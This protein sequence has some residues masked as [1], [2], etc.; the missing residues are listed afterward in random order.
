MLVVLE[1]RF[2][3]ENI[4]AIRETLPE[5]V[6]Y[7]TTLKGL[8]AGY[9][10]DF[11]DFAAY[12]FPNM[13]IEVLKVDF[14]TYDAMKD[15]F[16]TFKEPVQVHLHSSNAL[17]S[18][19][20]KGLCDAYNYEGL[21]VDIMQNALFTIQ[22]DGSKRLKESLKSLNVENYIDL[23]GGVIIKTTSDKHL[24]DPYTSIVDYISQHFFEWRR[25]K[26]VLTN[27]QLMLHPGDGPEKVIIEE[28]RMSKAEYR[29]YQKFREFLI[30]KHIAQFKRFKN[31][32]IELSFA[33]PE[34]KNFIFITGSW[35]ESL[36]YR[37]IREINGVEDVK[38]GV[39][40]SWEGDNTVLRNELDVLATYQ[41]RL[42]VFSCKDTAKYH[43]GTL[44]ELMVYAQ[45]I[46][47]THVRKILVVTEMPLK[48]TVVERAQEMGIS[49]I[50]F[51]GSLTGF[52][53]QIER[54]FMNAD[55]LS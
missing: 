6:T 47:G 24:T 7:I 23:A 48:V 19:I 54:V 42:F 20:A 12:E 30:N 29:G 34:L 8:H 35:L 50:L 3:D 4:I 15:I 33:T 11:K 9:F 37:Y 52:K 45:K 17:M 18:I 26:S 38:C 36:T 39:S 46:G 25:L 43:E 49:L 28:S 53:R 22:K 44:N 1:D 14:A 31:G 16:K 55:I 32:H 13:L 10:E 2:N 40:F 41:S 27:P 51:D 21:Y 5:K